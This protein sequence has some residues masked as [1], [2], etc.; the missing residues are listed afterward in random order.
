MK[1]IQDCETDLKNAPHLGSQNPNMTTS[2]IN[3]A[4]AL[5]SYD[6]TLQ[7]GSIP[8]FAERGKDP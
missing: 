7:P 2:E 5:F 3:S 6:E 1:A 8:A 4:N